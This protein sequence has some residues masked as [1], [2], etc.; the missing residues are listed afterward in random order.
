M[1]THAPHFD[2]YVDDFANAANPARD[3]FVAHLLG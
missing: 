1:M 2:A 3:W